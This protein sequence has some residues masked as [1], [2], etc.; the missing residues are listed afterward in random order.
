MASFRASAPLLNLR[1]QQEHCAKQ[2][3]YQEAHELQQKALILEQKEKEKLL[4]EVR[5]KVN[6]AEA[7]LINKQSKE[8]AA[9]QKKLESKMLDRM[10]MREVEHNKILQ[11]YQN[12]RKE[13]ESQQNIE[14][15]KRERAYKVSERPGTGNSMQRSVMMSQTSSKMGSRMGS[16]AAASKPSNY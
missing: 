1:R 12:V 10:K 2:K 3:N 13:I 7:N 5:R 15:Q 4:E 8:M 9:L 6:A 16:R 11:R 14:R